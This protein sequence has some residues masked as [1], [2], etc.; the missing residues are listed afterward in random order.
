MRIKNKETL[1]NIA[2]MNSV[3]SWLAENIKFSE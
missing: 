1:E 2:L 3:K